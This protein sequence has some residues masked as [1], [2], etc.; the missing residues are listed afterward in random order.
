MIGGR[1]PPAAIKDY[2]PGAIIREFGTVQAM[3]DRKR[4]VEVT[5]RPRRRRRYDRLGQL[6]VRKGGV[7]LEHEAHYFQVPTLTIDVLSAGG[8]G[9]K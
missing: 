7:S 4:Q 8:A 6:G 9:P 5:P 1:I 2:Q 3:F